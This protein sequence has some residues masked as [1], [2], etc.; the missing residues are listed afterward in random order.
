[1]GAL[2]SFRIG[3]IGDFSGADSRNERSDTA[4]LRDIDLDSFE[5]V[6]AAI[7]PEIHPALAFCADLHFTNWRDFHP[8]GLA[9]RVPGLRAL[10]EARGAVDDPAG[11]R[12]YLAEADTDVAVL[13]SPHPRPAT[14]PEPAGV[15]EHESADVAGDELL[16]AMLGATGARGQ[17]P[18]AARS[19]A[20]AASAVDQII[21]EIV[22]QSSDATDYA[23]R[24]R[25]RDAIDGELSKR[26]RAILWQDDFRRLEA[27]WHSLRDLVRSSATAELRISLADF[28]QGALHAEVT[29]GTKLE[30]STLFR[31]LLENEQHLPGE[32]ALDLLVSDYCFDASEQSQRVLGYLARLAERVGLPILMGARGSATSIQHASEQELAGWNELQQRPGARW[33]GLCAP[34]LLLR[35]PYGEEIAPVECFAFEERASADRPNDYLWG[36]AAFGLAR[37]VARTIERRGDLAAL[38]AFLELEDLPLHVDRQGG[39]PRAQGPVEEVLTEAR[40]EAWSLMGLIPVVGIRGSDRARILALRSLA[41]SRLF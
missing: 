25:W 16:E 22:A 4:P 3:V 33:L 26:V 21:G 2:E 29:C 10:L 14:E 6:L 13:S 9:E 32:P 38:E 35:Q 19:E 31:L 11:M 8:D 27:A 17:E 15:V 41:G 12:R 18:S 20:G 30:D 40:L 28:G 1:M 37:A 24:D 7:G 23:Q 34:R 39:E 36:G 5:R